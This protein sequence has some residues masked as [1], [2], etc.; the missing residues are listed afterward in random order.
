MARRMT[1]SDKCITTCREAIGA[2]ITAAIAAADKD[3]L[4]ALF[5]ADLE[6]TA[7]QA[8]RAA[9]TEEEPEPD[10]KDGN[11]AVK[12][13]RTRTQRPVAAPVAEA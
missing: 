9:G 8:A 2:S 10:A 1:P 7:I 4:G 6:L 11:G 5:F 3:A 13:K 12:P